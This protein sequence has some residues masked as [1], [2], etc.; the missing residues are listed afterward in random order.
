MIDDTTNAEKAPNKSFRVRMTSP[1]TTRD[2]SGGSTF[3]LGH[4]GEISGH[5]VG[6]RRSAKALVVEVAQLTRAG[7]ATLASD[8]VYLRPFLEQKRARAFQPQATEV[9]ADREPQALAEP[10]RQIA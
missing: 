6:T 7:E 9:L 8:V 3:D 2:P 1:S 4:R 10:A 5:P